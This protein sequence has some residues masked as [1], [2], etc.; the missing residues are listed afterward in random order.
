M[1]KVKIGNEKKKLPLT[2][3]QKIIYNSLFTIIK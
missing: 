2:P 1:I 3:K